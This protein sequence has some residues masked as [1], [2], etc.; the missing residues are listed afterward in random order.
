MSR[1]PDL[2][3]FFGPF[4]LRVSRGARLDRK[5]TAKRDPRW[6]EKGGEDQGERGSVKPARTL[7]G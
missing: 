1:Q 4:R 7:L 5:P 6:T 3:S 2:P